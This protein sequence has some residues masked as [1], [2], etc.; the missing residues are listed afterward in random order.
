MEEGNEIFHIRQEV[1]AKLKQGRNA[2]SILKA[3]KQKTEKFLKKHGENISYN[4]GTKWKKKIVITEKA[5][6]RSV[7]CFDKIWKEFKNLLRQL[8]QLLKFLR[9]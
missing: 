9:R 5:V 3:F 7:R 6:A 2:D 4:E 1:Y 8:A